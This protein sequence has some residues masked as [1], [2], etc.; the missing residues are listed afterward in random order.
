MLTERFLYVPS[1]LTFVLAFVAAGLVCA[2]RYRISGR[3]ALIV[4]APS[5]A[6][7]TPLFSYVDILKVP[8]DFSVLAIALLVGGVVFVPLAALGAVVLNG[9]AAPVKGRSIP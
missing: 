3:V 5:Y 8:Q 1:A 4:C 9:V 6:A 7:L 2:R